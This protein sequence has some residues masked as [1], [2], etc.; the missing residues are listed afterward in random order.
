MAE[1]YSVERAWRIDAPAGVVFAALTDFRRWREWSS[2][3]DLDPA[4][5][6]AYSGPGSG[7][8]A[9][10]AWSGN[11]KAGTGRME[12][13]RAEHPREV[14]IALDFE[15]PFRSHNLTSFDLEDQGAHTLVTWRMTGPR[16]VVMKLLGRFFSMEDLVGKDFEKGLERLAAVAERRA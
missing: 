5:E 1:T 15:K 16:P 11:R 9:V 10:M 3:E 8:G 7:V 12:L 13:L 4:M 2:W 14:E 6:R